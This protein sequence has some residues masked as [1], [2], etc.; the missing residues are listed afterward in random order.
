M[1]DGYDGD[2]KADFAVFRPDGANWF[3]QR[4]TDGIL[5]QQFGAAGGLPTPAAFVR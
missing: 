2:G 5:I 1:D 3:I 4:S